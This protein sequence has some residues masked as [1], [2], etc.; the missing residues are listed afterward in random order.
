MTTR[1]VSWLI[2][3]AAAA[4]GC[5]QLSPE[6]QVIRDAAGAMGGVEAV[7]GATTLTMEGGG[8]NYRLGQNRNPDAEL[9]VSEVESYRSEVDLQ[10]HRWRVEV[11]SP[12]FLG[13]MVTQVRAMDQDVAFNIGG[14][15]TAQRVGSLAATAR[16][17]EYYHHPLTLLQA[18]LAEG[19]ATVSNLRQEMDH[20]VVDIT[21]A[22]GSQ[23]TLHLDPETSL[24]LTISSTAYNS[25]LGDVEITTSFSDYADADG[26]MLPQVTSWKLHEYR[27]ADLRLTNTVNGEIGDLAAPADVASAPEPE[28]RP[29]N[30][31]V[32]E[33]ASGV[34]LLA[35]QSHHSVL[36][37][38]PQYT[39][40][41]E[42]PQNDMRML[43]VIEQAR[44]LVPDKPLRYVVN[45]HHHFDHC[46]GLRAAVA[47]GLTVITHE[48]NQSLFEDLVAR[49]HTIVADHLAR[50][51]AP[52]MLETVTGDEK[53]ELRDG[54]R[55]VEIY[56]ITDS[57][58]NDGIL[59][60]YLPSER[61]LIEADVF[62]PGRPGQPFAANL[63]QNIQDRGLR[64]DRIAPIHGQVVPFSGLQQAVKALPPRR[65][66]ATATSRNRVPSH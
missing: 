1:L 34:W 58:H 52:L 3:L 64:V 66:D 24:P 35:G 17:A 16:H 46:G 42:A 43:A 18:A 47:E 20:N 51:P 45:T 31:T 5:A 56:R 12:N 7:R 9:P 27:S 61:I 40:L 59:M 22:D 62:T 37:D 36:I 32:E 48:I 44:E 21:T 65:T 49:Q 2:V 19:M 60:V 63:L 57:G 53:Y 8:S 28:P 38:F 26:L 29:A 15:G 23:L 50:N 10:S 13:N 11:T 25:N 39:V 41:V 54:D 55:V 6:M 30:V 4:Y 14:S 33:L